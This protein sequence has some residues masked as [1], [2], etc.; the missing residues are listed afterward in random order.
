[1]GQFKIRLGKTPHNLQEEDFQELGKGTEGYSGS[2]ITIIVKEAMMMPVRR[3]QTATKF[4]KMADGSLM[5]TFPSDPEGLEMTLMQ[6]PPEK[7]KAPDVCVDD[8][9]QALARIKPSVCA[10]DL[11]QQIEFTQNFGSDG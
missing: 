1:M 3:C 4:K 9:W 7:L 11:E 2:D 10:A 8:F 5:P 6:V